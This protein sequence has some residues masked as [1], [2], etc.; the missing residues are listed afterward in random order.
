MSKIISK[1][2][3][4]LIA[5]LLLLEPISYVIME[6][7]PR[8]PWIDL[9][10]VYIVLLE[11]GLIGKILVILCTW[12]IMRVLN[13]GQLSIKSS[14]SSQQIQELRERLV[15]DNTSKGG[16]KDVLE[17]MLN[18]MS[19]IQAYYA[20]SKQHAWLS[21]VLAVVFCILG[22][23]L[24]SQ[25]LA[26]DIESQQPMIIGAIGGTLSEIFAGTAL[27]V[28]KSSL[29]QLN[30]YYLALHENERFLS[31]VNLL[32]RLS[33]E[34]REDALMKIIDNSLSNIT[35]LVN[36]FSEEK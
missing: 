33:D 13:E 36:E 6:S 26:A 12:V 5:F 14:D 25:A 22:F 29:K 23:I 1:W 27:L 11:S 9:R 4:L 30:R 28:H 2:Y 10:D 31:T 16:T 21:F 32:D 7:I 35:S 17:L 18:N 3:F 24:F 19:E 15:V 34:K 8:L 20:I